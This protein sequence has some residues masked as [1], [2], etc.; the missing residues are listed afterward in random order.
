MFEEEV[1]EWPPVEPAPF[2]T[3]KISYCVCLNTMGQDRKYSEEEKLAALRTVQEYRDRWEALEKE[4]L[5]NDVNLKL[6]RSEYF[7]QYRDNFEPQDAQ[8]MEKIV[9]EAINSA[10]PDEG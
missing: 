9:E 10:L 5:A 6:E 2:L 3:R 4:N 1:K 7:V 8:E